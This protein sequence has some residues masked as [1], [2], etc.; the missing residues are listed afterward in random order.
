MCILRT[1]HSQAVTL[2][3]PLHSA[4]D[5]AITVPRLLQ[6]VGRPDKSQPL[7]PRPFCDAL[8]AYYKV[9]RHKQQFGRPASSRRAVTEHPCLRHPEYLPL[10][11]FVTVSRLAGKSSDDETSKLI[12]NFIVPDCHELGASRCRYTRSPG[13]VGQQRRASRCTSNH[14]SATLKRRDCP[15]Y[16]TITAP[17]A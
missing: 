13:S 8:M 16:L 15:S 4:S 6:R 12:S 3:A 10:S 2:R 5:A 1:R 17:L 7:G 9:A 11:A 14:A